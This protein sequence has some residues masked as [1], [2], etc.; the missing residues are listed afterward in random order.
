MIQTLLGGQNAETGRMEYKMN[1]W[2][3]NA[4]V[5]SEVLALEMYFAGA[6]S[7]GNEA[8][9]TK[10]GRS[11]AIDE[12][13]S[14]LVDYVGGGRVFTYDREFSTNEDSLTGQADFALLMGPPD[15]RSRLWQAGQGCFG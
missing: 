12:L 5:P 1:D 3:K 14:H 2:I 13:L 4:G 8:E 6:D 9:G 7:W 11:G 15:G 10:L